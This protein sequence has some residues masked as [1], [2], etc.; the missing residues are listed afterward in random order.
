MVAGLYGAFASWSR[1]AQSRGRGRQGTGHRPAAARPAV[2]VHRD[3]G[4]DL[5]PD[6]N[7]ARAH[8]Q[9]LG[10]DLAAQCLPHQGRA[11]Y[12]H[13]RLDPGDGRAPVPRDRPRGHDRRPALSHQQRPGQERRGLRGADRRL[14]RRPDLGREHG[15]LRARRGH[16]GAGL[17]HRPVH[18]RPACQGAR[19]PGRPA[20]RPR[21]GRLPMHNI[22][23]R[24]SETP[25]RLRRRRRGS[26]S[27]PPRSWVRSASTARRSRG[28]RAKASSVL[29]ETSHD[30]LVPAGMALAAVC[31]GDRAALCRRR[32]TARRRRDHPRPRRQRRR[33]REG[34]GAHFGAGGGGDRVARRR[35]CRR[36]DQP[37][38]AA[39]GARHRG[40]GR[41][42]RSGPGAS[43]G[44][45]PRACPARSPRLSTRSKP[46]AAWRPARPGSSRWSRPRRPSSASPRS[47]APTR[48]SARSTSGPRISRPR[49]AFCPR[50][51]RS[52]CR[53][54]W[55]SSPPA[56]PASC[57]WALSARSPSFTISKVS[58]RRSAARAGSAL[59]APR[60]SIRARSRS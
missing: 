59:S 48:G 36:A 24:L 6:R 23:P 20:R 49:P 13:L 38:L 46:S 51:R 4:G 3:R 22:I 16:R 31:A 47:P 45:Q 50:P 34:A 9:P 14:H 27:T 35:R 30:R 52:R 17:R 29:P 32:G 56:P 41:P 57:R 43:Q 7:G 58:A 8:R 12:R 44:R 39:R 54:R 18:G 2:L 28:S 42:R 40:G 55:R 21:S 15:D 37:A 5:P 11:L 33:F 25:G 1:C 60:S 19:D 26:A 53:S 10:D